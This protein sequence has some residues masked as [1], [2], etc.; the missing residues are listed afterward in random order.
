MKTFTSLH[1]SDLHY[2]LDDLESVYS[3]F[4]EY[5]KD[6]STNMIESILCKK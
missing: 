2:K 4:V 6:F 1:S 5:Y 3:L